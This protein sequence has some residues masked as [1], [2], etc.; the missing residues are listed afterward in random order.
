MSVEIDEY[1]LF[2]PVFIGTLFGDICTSSL[3]FFFSPQRRLPERMLDDRL[4]GTV[5]ESKKRCVLVDTVT[6]GSVWTGAILSRKSL[7]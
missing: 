1:N 3:F 4:S 7:S 2:S 6:L 5:A